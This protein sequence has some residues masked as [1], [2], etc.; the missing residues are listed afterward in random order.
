MK[1]Q[2]LKHKGDT[3]VIQPEKQSQGQSVTQ[4]KAPELHHC[5][6]MNHRII[7][8]FGLEGNLKII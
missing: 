2:A 6:S 7:E 3:K 4:R 1:P 8:R 5:H